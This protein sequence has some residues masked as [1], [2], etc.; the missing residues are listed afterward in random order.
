MSDRNKQNTADLIVSVE[1]RKGGVGKTTAALCLGRLL[2]KREYAVLILDLDVTGTNA[3]DVAGSPFWVKDIHTIRN[4]AGIAHNSNGVPLPVNLLT[5]FERGFM[6]GKGAPPFSL[7]ETDTEG[8]YVDLTRANLLGSQIYKTDKPRAGGSGVETSHDKRTTCIERPGILF[9]DLYSHWLLE[10]V[11]HI[12]GDFV[13]VADSSG[14]SKTAIILD[15]SPG[16]VGIAPAIHEWLTDY[17]PAIGKFLTVSSLDAQDLR[18]CERAID[19]L[20]G[21]YMAKWATSR[22]FVDGA[23]RGDGI[24]VAKHQEAFFMQFA[25]SAKGKHATA[26]PCVLQ[27]FAATSVGGEHGSRQ[28]RHIQRSPRQ[29]HCGRRQSCSPRG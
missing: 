2:R 26:D 16:Y 20:H 24:R 9:D 25:T 22:L 23:D 28:R 19:A 17:G 6:V 11:K 8:L 5:L 13:R 15:N 21:L 4:A 18:A 1:S 14:H 7:S 27:I 12:I 3:A 29:V 10:F